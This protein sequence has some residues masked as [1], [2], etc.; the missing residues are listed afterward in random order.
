MKFKVE[1]KP[2]TKGLHRIREIARSEREKERGDRERKYQGRGGEQGACIEYWV[3]T[4]R[5]HGSG[6]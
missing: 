4:R 5:V 2:N 1:S 3:D 6:M